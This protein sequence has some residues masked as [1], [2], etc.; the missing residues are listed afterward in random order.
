MYFQIYFLN[1]K[2]KLI[3]SAPSAKK[4][5]LVTYKPTFTSA[6]SALNVK[7]SETNGHSMNL[8]VTKSIQTSNL[9]RSALL[10]STRKVT[11]AT[12]R[13]FTRRLMQAATG[14]GL[15]VPTRTAKEQMSLKRYVTSVL[16]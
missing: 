13:S 10:K 7:D 15:S 3:K 9:V 12:L 1:R 4:K 2:V 11:C 8:V 6:F 16:Q 5:C 14:R